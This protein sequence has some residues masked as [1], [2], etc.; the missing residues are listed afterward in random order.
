MV[1]PFYWIL[2]V[3]FMYALSA[4]NYDNWVLVNSPNPIFPRAFGYAA[5]GYS[6]LNNII[7]IVGGQ[8]N[9][10]QLT[11]FNCSSNKIIDYG[12]SALPYDVWGP[13]QFYA[14][15]GSLLYVIEQSG[16]YLGIFNVDT[17]VYSSNNISIP[18]YVGPATSCLVAFDDGTNEYLAILGGSESNGYNWKTR[19]QILNLT[20]L[21]WLGSVTTIPSMNS[22]RSVSS[23]NSI[24][25]LIHIFAGMSLSSTEYLNVSDMNNIASEIWKYGA[26]LTS[27]QHAYSRSIV[28][29]N[30]I[31][32]IGGGETIS[33]WDK[34]YALNTD[35]EIRVEGYLANAIA[36]TSAIVV[37][38]TGYAFGGPGADSSGGYSRL[39]QTIDLSPTPS[40]TQ[41]PTNPTASPSEITLHPTFNP[42][43]STSDPTFYPTNEPTVEPS[44]HPTIDPTSYPTSYP[45]IHP[46]SD[47]TTNP[48]IHPTS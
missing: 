22:G 29:K 8:T 26:S 14:Q 19:V 12:T 7:W 15:H 36:G 11:A 21:D 37:A 41:Y 40:P 46:T 4:L 17:A 25:G 18:F 38:D 32:I 31:L 44:V 45:T 34:V 33:Q 47:P 2:L 48:T 43:Q 3:I 20:T 6:S 35:L 9:F 30:D 13:A 10:R 16:Y 23:C 39:Y 27:G 42:T 1:S 28:Y 24:N 5:V